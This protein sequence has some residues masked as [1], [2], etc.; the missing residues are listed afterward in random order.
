MFYWRHGVVQRETVSQRVF[1][2]SGA[3]G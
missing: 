3:E 1:V 2:D